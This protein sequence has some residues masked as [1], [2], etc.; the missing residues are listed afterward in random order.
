[1]SLR[2]QLRLLP[3]LAVLS[4]GCA[5]QAVVAGQPPPTSDCP[6]TRTLRLGTCHRDEPPGYGTSPARPLQWGVTAAGGL[7]F[8]RLLCPSGALATAHRKPRQGALVPWEV[9]C[10]GDP[11]EHVWYT[12]PTQ[13]ADPCPPEG[14]SVI[15]DDALQTYVASVDAQQAGNTELALKKAREA[16]HMAPANELLGAWLGQTLVQAGQAQDAVPLFE[17]VVRMNPEDPEP[18][19]YLAMAQRAAG[20]AEPYHAA[21]ADLL[22]KLPPS[23][24]LVPE[25]QCLRAEHLQ[26]LGHTAEAQSLVTASCQGGW[27]GCC[28]QP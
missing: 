5:G 11:T 18:K 2:R 8:G 6:A 9:R 19:L 28:K 14:F 3:L 27:Q 24:P 23:H 22:T 21:V 1:M 4:S 12:T 17:A 10:P 16:A 7:Y 26:E 13:C 20:H 15:P 25:L